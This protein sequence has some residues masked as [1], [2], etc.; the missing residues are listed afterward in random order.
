MHIF[1]LGPRHDGWPQSIDTR[2]GPFASWASSPTSGRLRECQERVPER[3]CVVTLESE[4][5]LV[6]EQAHKRV[7]KGCHV[8]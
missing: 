6:G 5:D 1:A 3:A 2:A 7:V 8:Q 4:R